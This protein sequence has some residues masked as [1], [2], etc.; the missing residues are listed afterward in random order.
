MRAYKLR[1]TL[2]DTH[3]PIWRE[4]IV[5]VDITFDE[6]HVILQYTMGWYNCHLYEFK[7]GD[8]EVTTDEEALDEVRYF[9]TIEGMKKLAELRKSRFFVDRT[10]T[11]KDVDEFI[12]EYFDSNKIIDYTYDFGDDWKHEIDVLEKIENYPHDYPQVLKFKGN[13]PP[14]DC[15]GT[16]GYE[17]FL[18]IINN[19]SH[20]DNEENVLWAEGQGYGSYDIDEINVALEEAFERIEE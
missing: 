8:I 5:P 11:L 10:K 3:I 12:E 17:E 15:G 19:K 2:S 13:C 9:K 6:L 7:I 1:V 18:K 14:E 20:T 4:I 16:R